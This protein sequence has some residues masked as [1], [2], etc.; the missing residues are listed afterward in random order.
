VIDLERFLRDWKSGNAP[1]FG[2]QSKSTRPHDPLYR[3][4]L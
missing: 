1:L 4:L 2:L 3:D